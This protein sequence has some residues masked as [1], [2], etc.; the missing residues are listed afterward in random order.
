MVSAK[1]V[2]PQ[3]IWNFLLANAASNVKEKA[4]NAMRQRLPLADIMPAV[5]TTRPRNIASANTWFSAV[6]AL[7]QDASRR[8][9]D[10]EDLRKSIE[11]VLAA[12]NI[13]RLLCA[14]ITKACPHVP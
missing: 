11:N 6:K 3:L 12:G 9:T 2:V 14:D 4:E 13:I 1:P 10:E 5:L 8:S 7:Q